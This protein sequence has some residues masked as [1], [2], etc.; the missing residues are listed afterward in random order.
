MDCQSVEE[1]L[2]LYFYDELA[3]EERAALEAHLAACARCAEA[4]AE[5]RRLRAALGARPSREPSPELLVRC[6]WALDEALDR[7]EEGW[8]GLVRSWLGPSPSRAALRLSTALSVLLVGISLGW[9]LHRSPAPRGPVG[10]T[11]SNPWIGA[12][13][14]DLRINGISQVT[15][16]P[17]TGAVRITL[18]AQRRVTLEGSLDDPRIR[19]VLLSTVREYDNP[20]IRRDTLDA[21]RAHSDN[22]EVRAA[23]LYAMRNDANAGVRLEALEAAREMEWSPEV[24][25]ALLGTLRHDKNPGVRV[26]AINVLVEH[27]DEDALPVFEEL[28]ANDPNPYVR[29]QCASAVRELK[30]EKF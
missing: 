13:L 25:L 15:P 18:D 20:G 23:L 17:Q 16:D 26:A 11:E 27:A 3:A 4:A 2:T 8:R 14:G 7:E 28:A 22:P 12:D 21:L 5:L 10:G 19:Q 1:K 24:R 29:L 30:R 6:R 9:T